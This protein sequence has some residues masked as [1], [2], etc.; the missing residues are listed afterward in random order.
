MSIEFLDPTHEDGVSGFVR[1]ARLATLEGATVGF[2][3]NGKEGTKRFFAALEREF[4]Q[5]L[6]VAKVVLLTKR[7]YSAPAEPGIM[8][9]TSEW[10]AVVAGV[11]D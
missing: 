6:G 2:I 10:D 8:A 11:G 9:R 7:N 5:G 4:T 3:S 1:A